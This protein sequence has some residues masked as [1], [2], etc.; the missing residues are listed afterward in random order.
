MW[1]KW[2]K[3]WLPVFT[4]KLKGQRCFSASVVLPLG[5]AV[6]LVV[7]DNLSLTVKSF[8]KQGIIW[9]V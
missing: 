8:E 6:F 5:G 2:A 4:L 3:P 9:F 7:H 1:E